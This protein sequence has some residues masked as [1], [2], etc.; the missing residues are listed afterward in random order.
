MIRIAIFGFGAVGQGVAEV[1]IEKRESL[2]KLIGEYKVV[3]ITD[4]KGGIVNEDGIDLVETL[5]IKR[6][7]SHLPEGVTTLDVIKNLDFDV[8]IEVTPTNIQTGE[9]GLTH[10]EECLK[11]GVNVIT[12]NKGPLV[13]AYKRLMKLAEQNNAKLMFEATVGG[14]MPLIKLVKGEL[15][16]NEIY[17]IRGILNGTCNYIL[18]RMESEKLPYEQILAEAQELKIAEANPTY[19]VEGIDAAAKLVII[20]NALMDMDV[21]FEDVERVGITHITPEAFELAR[22]RGY[23]IRLIAEVDKHKKL[24]RVSPRLIPLQHPLAIG[25]TLN[26]VLIKTYLAGDIVVIGKGAGKKETASAIISDL[27]TLYNINK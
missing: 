5:R 8:G 14:A 9:P 20:A 2:R 23:T 21:K 12:S 4:S 11:K 24:L 26:A 16:G 10:I 7:K 1:L 17:A 13:V 3:A 22:E 19:D 18:S 27:I 6:L 25:G 15:A